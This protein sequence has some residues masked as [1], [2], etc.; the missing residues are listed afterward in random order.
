MNFKRFV[1]FLFIFGWTGCFTSDKLS[2]QNFAY[3]YKKD[4]SFLDAEF[5][6]FHF[7]EDS[8]RLNFKISTTNLLYTREENKEYTASLM[9]S[10][11]L[12]NS[13]ELP[14]IADSSSIII[15]DIRTAQGIM[16]SDNEKS[17]VKFLNFKSNK[18][19]SLLEVKITDLN[20]KEVYR[21]YLNYDRSTDQ[22]GQS[23]EITKEKN[24]RLLMD[25][26]FQAGEKLLISYK[27]TTVTKLYVKYYSREF[28]LALPPFNIERQKSFDVA[29]DSLFIINISNR[30]G[31]QSDKKGFYY[32]QADTAK[33][34]G[35]ALFCFYDSYP[36][37]T[38]PTQLLEP[39]R[40]LTNKKEFDEL[41]GNPNRKQAIDKFW[42]DLG[43]NQERARELI[44]KYYSR[45]QNANAFFTSYLEGWKTDRGLIYIIFGIPNIINKNSGT[46]YWV[47]G[48][49]SNVLSLN[50]TFTK[51][52]NPFSDNDFSLNRTN[53]Y[54][55]SWYNAIEVWREGRIYNDN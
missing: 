55:S 3:L 5:A 37:L 1:F 2:R 51:V 6:I 33:K 25:N 50:F 28:P 18:S 26:F 16:T 35:L 9:I 41:S 12:L 46:E 34:D 4:A 27:D 30:N 45:V 17:I 52:N 23:F 42:L 15:K 32:F 53:Y 22:G 49:A 38:T 29:A 14:A 10:Y 21:Y 8:S 54:E 44:R 24:H 11:K 20:K 13:Y 47:Y 43:G 19:A 31:F 39:L 40:Y 36:Q 7:S 48:D